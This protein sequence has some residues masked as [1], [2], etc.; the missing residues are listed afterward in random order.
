MVDRTLREFAVF[1]EGESS[2]SDKIH[3][4]GEGNILDELQVYAFVNLQVSSARGL[5]RRIYHGHNTPDSY[6]PHHPHLPRHHAQVLV[7]S[8]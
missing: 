4:G 6:S 5:A 3:Y 1:A 8:S 7:V 2:R